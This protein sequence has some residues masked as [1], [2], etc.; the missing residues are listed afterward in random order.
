MQV[1]VYVLTEVLC[2]D[3]SCRRYLPDIVDAL[4]PLVVD[5]NKL[6]RLGLNFFV[7]KANLL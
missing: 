6:L 5:V 2:F 3:I 4:I 1:S 7:D